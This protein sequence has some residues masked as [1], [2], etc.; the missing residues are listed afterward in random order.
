VS[1][2][3]PATRSGVGPS[4]AVLVV[5]ARAGEKWACE[6]LFRRHAPRANGLA[7]R[8]LGRDPDV[9]DVVQDAFVQALRRLDS[10]DDPQ[11]FA[12]WLGQIVVRTASKLLRTRRLLT[13]L[14][15]RRNEAPI[16]LDRF[17]ARSAPPDAVIALRRIYA[18]VDALP[19]DVRV[20]L[21]LR[22]V[23][24]YELEEIA[25]TVGVSLATVKRKI[26]LGDRALEG[27]GGST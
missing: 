16:D 7:L 15:L 18:V 10:L 2:P 25:A 8:V 22:R 24:G 1:L 9:D 17:L 14:G 11:A 20:P 19:I 13:R 5:A 26:A 23:E 27:L 21:I 12:A 6:A 4:D 3:N